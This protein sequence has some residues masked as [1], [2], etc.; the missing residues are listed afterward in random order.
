MCFDTARDTRDVV[1]NGDRILVAVF[2]QPRQHLFHGRAICNAARHALFA[3]NGGNLV[4]FIGGIF[5]AARFLRAEAVALFDLA[6]ARDPAIDGG[7]GRALYV[8]IRGHGVSFV[9]GLWSQST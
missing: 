4:A 9:C 1:N 6:R 8:L 7:D 3:E 2:A 5:A